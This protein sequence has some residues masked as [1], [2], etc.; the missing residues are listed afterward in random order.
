[1]IAILII[2]GGIGYQ[3][4]IEIY[5]WLTGNFTR[6]RHSF[7]LNFKVVTS[8]T[9]FLLASGFLLFFLIEFYNPQTLQNLSLKDKIL[10]AFFQSVTTRTAGFN[11]IDIG[12]M[13][14]AG[15]F[16]TMGFMFVGASPSGT[17]GGIK[18]TTFNILYHCTRSVLRG[19]ESV[20]I[21]KREVPNSLILKAVA[22]VFGS[23]MMVIGVTFIISL[24]EFKFNPSLLV[25]NNQNLNSVQ[26]FFEVISAFATVGL[27]TGIT[28]SLSWLSQLMLVLTMYTGRVGVLI[29]MAAIIGESRPSVIQYPEENLLVG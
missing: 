10:A 18:T 15:L 13:T 25:S 1:V 29:F 5:L 27:S 12:Q 17:G 11:T 6:N 26:I 9:I 19:N 7:S 28:A 2:F 16:L 8:T 24:V 3:V 4:I 14:I 23:A 22:V 21:Y 20:I